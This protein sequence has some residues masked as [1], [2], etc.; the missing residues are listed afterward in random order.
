MLESLTAF[1]WASLFTVTGEIADKTQLVILGLALKY[2]SPFKVFLGGLLGHA[3]MD[4]I[5]IVFGTF[6]GVSLQVAWLH[7]IVGA[8]FITLG[9]YGIAKMRLKKKKEE[10]YKTIML[11]SPF[12]TTFVMVFFTEIGDR[13]QIASGL[14]A[15]EF[16]LPIQIFLGVVIGLA[17]TIGLNVFVGSKLAEHLPAKFVKTVTNIIF[18]AF[19]IIT[20]LVRS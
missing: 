12:R 6:A 5:A 2:R 10:E 4:G 20:I 8:L 19:G 1:L 7:Y 14:L 18:I 3:I 17:I 11:A 13:T 9:V 15:A 16:K